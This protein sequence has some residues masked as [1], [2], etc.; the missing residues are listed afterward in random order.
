M[1]RIIKTCAALLMMISALC[2]FGC[3]ETGIVFKNGP[4][5]PN[6]SDL[7]DTVPE[8][9]VADKANARHTTEDLNPNLN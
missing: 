3:A 5:G 7:L 9:L 4:A 6:T 2:L 1:M 8:G